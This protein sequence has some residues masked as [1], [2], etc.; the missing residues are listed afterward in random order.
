VEIIGTTPT[1]T[2]VTSIFFF[3]MN[4]NNIIQR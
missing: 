2:S 4:N 3:L 1:G